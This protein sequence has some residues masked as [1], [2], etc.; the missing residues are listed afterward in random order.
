MEPSQQR[1]PQSPPRVTMGYTVSPQQRPPQ[2]S[3]RATMGQLGS[4]LQGMTIAS[5]VQRTQQRPG[6]RGLISTF[7]GV[8]QPLQPQGFQ[9]GQLNAAA[10]NSGQ[11]GTVRP[12][13]T[14]MSGLTAAAQFATLTLASSSA[15]SIGTGSR[16]TTSSAV[17][18]FA[19]AISTPLATSSTSTTTSNQA[20]NNEF[21]ITAVSVHCQPQ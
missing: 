10:L 20:G 18:W 2:R 3:P 19:P 16:T 7:G 11:M 14:T 6:Q 12:P 21:S 4:Q 17:S 15:S 5:P 8:G 9:W 13:V 1:P